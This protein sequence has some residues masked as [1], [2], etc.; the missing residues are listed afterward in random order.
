[1]SRRTANKKLTK[2]YWLSRKRSPKQLIVCVEPK[3]WRG[4]TNFL[5]RFAPDV[6]PPLLNAFRRYCLQ[7]F[8]QHT[9]KALECYD[10]GPATEK[11]IRVGMMPWYVE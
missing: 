8:H 1:V 3:K 9:R 10:V 7:T 4:T 2:L 5:W 6:C 11:A